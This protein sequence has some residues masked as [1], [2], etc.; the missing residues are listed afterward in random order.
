MSTTLIAQLEESA[1]KLSEVASQLQALVKK[2]KNKHKYY[3]AH[4]KEACN[5]HAHVS[6]EQL[7]SVCMCNNHDGAH[8]GGDPQQRGEGTD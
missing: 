7:S 5:M 2:K 1:D 3:E 6:L 8:E 4:V